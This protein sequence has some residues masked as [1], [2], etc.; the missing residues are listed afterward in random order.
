MLQHMSLG[1]IELLSG[2]TKRE[3]E[4]RMPEV[5]RMAAKVADDDARTRG[6]PD[7][8]GYSPTSA[9]IV[10]GLARCPT[11]AT[12]TQLSYHCATLAFGC[13]HSSEQVR[14]S[15]I[16]YHWNFA[17]SGTR[18]ICSLEFECTAPYSQLRYTMAS[19]GTLI[20]ITVDSAFVVSIWDCRFA[21]SSF[22][23]QLFWLTHRR[24]VDTA[25]H[26]RS[27]FGPNVEA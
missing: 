6:P 21:L 2:T 1:R 18:R 3:S 4:R 14:T 5:D 26:V 8:A 13:E 24:R 23:E 12:S 16:N 9:I 19:L 17:S 27:R 10:R 15:S 25:L 11:P 7:A 22:Q 20:L